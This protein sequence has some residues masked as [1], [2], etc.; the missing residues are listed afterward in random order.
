MK[1][2]PPESE[3][4]F[5]DR[6]IRR[7]W[8]VDDAIEAQLDE[9]STATAAGSGMDRSLGATV[10]FKDEKLEKILGEYEDYLKKGTT[11]GEKE[12]AEDYVERRG[13]PDSWVSKLL[14]FTRRRS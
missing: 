14:E 2:L 9:T 12:E 3:R 4:N 6:L 8:S 11:K 10:R 13:L 1:H 7:E 5:L